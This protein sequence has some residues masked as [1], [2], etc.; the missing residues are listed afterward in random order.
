MSSAV[1]GPHSPRPGA[2]ASGARKNAPDDPFLAGYPKML[3]GVLSTGR[4]LSAHELAACREA[5][6]LAAE[7]GVALRALLELYLSAT[8]TTWQRAGP[9]PATKPK[10]PRGVDA[11]LRAVNDAIV[12]VTEGYEDAHHL[13]LRQE[14]A[15]RREF[16][17]DLFYGRGDPGS[18]AERAQRFGLRL[19][20]AHIVSIVKSDE[21]I[22][23]TTHVLHDV[24]T[25]LLQ[26]FGTGQLLFTTKD[27]V[28]VCIAPSTLPQAA[29]EL[30][31]QAA[32]ALPADREW[33]VGIGRAHPGPGGALRSY[34]EARASVDF[35]TRLDFRD[36]VVRSTDFLV[37]QVLLR[38]RAA[39]EDLIATV[40]APLQSARG[41]AAPL[42]ETLAAYF[43][44]GTI[45]AAADQLN[46]SVRA[47]SYRLDR[48]R[49]LSGYSAT[50]PTQRFTLQAAVLGARLLDWAG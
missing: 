17:D 24:E 34:E 41:G 32:K 39:I 18:L 25:V 22:D 36:R 38:D 1:R 11:G 14:E 45:Q 40:L 37:F 50:E 21:P 9:A 13:A 33:R 5:G 20:E 2:S 10:P 48:V 43:D 28:F 30:A 49:T 19:A 3:S 4:K 31:R 27:G 42:I 46:L 44:R 26:R 7:G 8:R 35:A 47:V 16:I 6:R 15:A 23:E 12:A 29:T